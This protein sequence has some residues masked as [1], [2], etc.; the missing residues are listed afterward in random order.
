MGSSSAY[1]TVSPSGGMTIYVDQFFWTS[2]KYRDRI[3]T[4]SIR[5]TTIVNMVGVKHHFILCE[6]ESGSIRVAEWLSDGLKFYR[7]VDCI[8]CCYCKYLGKFKLGEVFQAIQKASQ[9]RKYDWSSYNCNHWTQEVA[10][11]LGI[12]LVIHS[13]C[14]CC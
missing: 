3:A 11:N 5:S 14:N 1:G 10:K 8:N 2:K 4:V 6:C 13:L 12:D 7:M 9:G